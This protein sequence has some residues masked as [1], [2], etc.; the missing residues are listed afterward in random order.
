MQTKKIGRSFLLLAMVVAMPAGI[1]HGQSGGY[2]SKTVRVI[3]PWPAGGGTDM[4]AR[5]IAQKLTELL[6]QQ[7][8][9]DNR[10]GASGIVGSEIAAKASAD[11]Y[12]VMIDNVTSH[13]TNATLYKQL[14]YNSL[15]DYAP[16][17]LLTTVTNVIVVHPSVPVKSLQELVALA[18]ARPG[19]LSFATFGTGGTTHLAGE[20]LKGRAGI[21]MVHVPYKGGAPAL[22][23]AVAGH[24]PVYFSVFNTSLAQ[25]KAGKLRPLATTG[26]ERS[27]LMLEVPTVAE[28]GYP[29][30]E[31]NNWYGMLTPAGVP[32]EILIR[33]N[34]ETRRTLQSPD[35][36]ERLTAQG[37]EIVPSTPEKLREH[38]AMETEKWAKVIK[39][40]N[41]RAE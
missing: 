24:V 25:I 4:L 11:G 32:R 35:V 41:V 31:A 33:L 34:T 2:P 16:V 14:A 15:R 39:A 7:V 37:Y 13:A 8:V 28:S 1:A 19:Q 12:T 38:M 5:P 23:D 10:G 40:A 17:T 9:V 29:G 20:M 36:I 6:A 21:D 27:T 26:I 22:V 3:V 18:R 30:F